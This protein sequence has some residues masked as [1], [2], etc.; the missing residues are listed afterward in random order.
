MNRLETAPQPPTWPMRHPRIAG[1]LL[2]LALHVVLLPLGATY[3]GTK[4]EAG[5]YLIGIAQLAY[6]LPASILLMKLGRVEMAK[7]MALAAIVTFM[8]NAAGCAAL[9][10]QL[11]QIDG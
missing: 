4:P 10:W 8:L 5:V 1:A 6:A 2:L 9:L 7:G 3:F 11:S